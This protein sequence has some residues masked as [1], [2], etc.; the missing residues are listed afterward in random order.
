[1][2]DKNIA[3]NNHTTLLLNCYT[4]VGDISHINAFIDSDANFDVETALRGNI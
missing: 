3:N 4:K 2:Q 1:M